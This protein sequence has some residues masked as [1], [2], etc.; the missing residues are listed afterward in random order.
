MKTIIRFLAIL[1]V[2][3]VGE[4]KSLGPV[5]IETLFAEADFVGIVQVTSG[6]LGKD[7]VTYQGR[8]IVI[9]KGDTTRTELQFGRFIGLGIGKK[10]LVFLQKDSSSLY[11]VMFE[12]FGEMGIEST[13]LVQDVNYIVQHP[14]LDEVVK[15]ASSHVVLPKSLKTFTVDTSKRVW[16]QDKI[17]KMKWVRV[18]DIITYLRKLKIS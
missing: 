15:I 9:V 14:S 18:N 1:I 6:V 2:L 10:Y 16:S 13:H 3:N 8:I 12:G 17:W 5:H 4:A 11:E 7:G